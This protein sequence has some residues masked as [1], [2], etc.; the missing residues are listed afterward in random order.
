[1][2]G[3]YRFE[4]KDDVADVVIASGVAERHVDAIEMGMSIAKD[5]KTKFEKI[6][7]R[8]WADGLVVFGIEPKAI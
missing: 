7:L 1:M 3:M 5:L 6:N 4:I 2:N 8:D